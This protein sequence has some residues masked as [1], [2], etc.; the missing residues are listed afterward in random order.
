MT[1]KG[2]NICW[3][4]GGKLIKKDSLKEKWYRM[5][6]NV[7]R[8]GSFSCI[9]IRLKKKKKRFNHICNL[10]KC[11]R[12]QAAPLRSRTQHYVAD[13]H[14]KVST[15]TLLVKQ[16]S[17][18]TFFSSWTSSFKAYTASTRLLKETQRKYWRF[19][20]T[21]SMFFWVFFPFHFNNHLPT[22]LYTKVTLA[23]N[24]RLY[25]AI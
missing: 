13:A 17:T 24:S 15:L 7:L 23:S 3:V 10:W 14:T 20:K 5:S 18:F 9:D 19:C 16:V 12:A 1:E 4:G 6:Y 11:Q 22:H 21:I 25:C 8:F 2:M